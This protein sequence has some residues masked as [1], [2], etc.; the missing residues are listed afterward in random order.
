M[1][2][3]LLSLEETAL[4]IYIRESNFGFAIVLTMH[5]IGLSFLLGANTI[6]A[7]RLLGLATAIPIKPLRLLFPFMWA[8]FLLAVL[9]GIALAVAHATTRLWNPILGVKLLLIA[10][11]APMMWVMQK[12]VSSDAAA[13][14][15]SQSNRR[16]ASSQLILW[17]LVLVA[18][19][20]IAYSA[21]ILGEGY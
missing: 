8:G 17:L 20:L 2:D 12:R 9:S 1:N 6:V 4:G 19:R 14:G 13:F 7:I 21:T 16:L 5:T 3:F 11:A 10:V 18:G 15:N